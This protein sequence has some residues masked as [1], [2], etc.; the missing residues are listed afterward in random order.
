[1][2]E[3]DPADE[4][5]WLDDQETL[6]LD[7]LTR[8]GVAVAGGL[9][10]EWSLPPYVSLWTLP[11]GGGG[12][13]WVISGDLPTDYLRDDRVTDARSAARAFG[14]RWREVAG[15]L[16]RGERHPTIEI[17]RSR[18]AAE[19]VELGDLLRRRAELLVRWSDDP[20]K[21]E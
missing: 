3:F 1:M 15:H 10:V 2:A 12:K 11:A 20:S 5:E 19:L 9:E 7:Y 14:R 18:P 17:G 4:M 6:A 8:E 16:A 21:W 13:T